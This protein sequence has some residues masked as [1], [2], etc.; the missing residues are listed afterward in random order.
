[1][2]GALEHAHQLAD[3]PRPGVPRQG[4]PGVRADAAHRDPVP[5]GE[6]DQEGSG[7]RGNVLEPVPE[8]RDRKRQHVETVEE[9]RAEPARRDFP[10]Q[11]PV[12][13][14]ED[15]DVH[16]PR[17]GISD[18]P[19]LPFLDHPK[20]AALHRSAGVPDLVQEQ[21]ALM[22]GLEEADTILMRAGE[23]SARVTE[24]LAL[25]Q[26]VRDGSEI[27]R[28]ERTR[29]PGRERVQGAR[30]ELLAGPGLSQDQHGGMASGERATSAFTPAGSTRTRFP[31]IPPP[32]MWAMPRTS[33]AARATATAGP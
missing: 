2:T 31:G 28:N 21:G 16:P 6:P 26:G 10:A 20:K 32:V 15:P 27:V 7:K 25:D 5:T 30:D 8:R 4:G 17:A 33:P 19:K 13:R 12:G 9:V 3:V 22:R 18:A 29:G 1:M 24:E 23:G 14:R 11:I